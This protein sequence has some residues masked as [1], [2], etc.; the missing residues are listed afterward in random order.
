MNDK[1]TALVVDHDDRLS[2]LEGRPAPTDEKVALTPSDQPG[3]LVEKLT[4]GDHVRL[5]VRQSDGGLQLEIGSTVER[6]PKGPKGERGPAGPSGG[7]S[8]ASGVRVQDEGRFLARVA[9]LN[10]TG[11]GIAISVEGDV[12]TVTVEPVVASTSFVSSAKWEVG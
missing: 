9:E 7:G 3:Y 4:A 11:E 5:R 12:A 1:L 2:T 10:F 8:P 6:G